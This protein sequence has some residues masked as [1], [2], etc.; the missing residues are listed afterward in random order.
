LEEREEKAHG[1]RC[2]AP[3]GE[4]SPRDPVKRMPVR[5]GRIAEI[6]EFQIVEDGKC[7]PFTKSLHRVG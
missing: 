1:V 3:P 6:K 7:V 4:Y 2:N 5:R